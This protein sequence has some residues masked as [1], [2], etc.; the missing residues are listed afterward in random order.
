MH[1]RITSLVLLLCAA[2]LPSGAVAAFAANMPGLFTESTGAYVPPEGTN[3]KGDR[4][5]PV[6]L[7]A[8]EMGYD[9]TNGIVIARGKVEIV[10]GDMVMN[11]DQVT[12]FQK[13]DKMI[14]EGNI[15]MLQP[16][17]D[18]M[19][20]ER[21][22]LTDAMKKGVVEAFKARM[23]DNSLFV[24]SSATK[25]S[26]SVTELKG[27]S[28]T[29]CNICEGIEPFWQLNAKEVK[30]DEG[31]Q[32]VKYKDAS[33]DIYGVPVFYTPVLSHPTPNSDAKS[34][35]LAPQYGNNSNLGTLVKVPVYWRIDHDKDAIIT[36]WYTQ[37]DGLV[38]QGDYRQLTNNGEYHFQGAITNPDKID[39]AGNT[40]EGNELRGYIFAQGKEALSDTVNVGFDINR[41][42]DQTFLRRY[43]LGVQPTLFS[44]LFVEAAQ[45][46]NYGLVQGL[47]IQGLRT[48]D[49][50]KT[51][52]LILPSVQ[53][54]YETTPDEYGI[55]YHISQD[56][57]SLT[58]D[59]GVDQS[60]L[61][62]TAGASIPY[63][64]DGGHL[65]TT[66][67][68]LRQDAY[69]SVN[70]PISGVPQDN[71]TYR[72]LPQAAFEW[73]YPLIN[74]MGDGSMTIE[75]IA[76]GVLQANG[77]NPAT[78]SNEDSRLLE[79]SDTNIFSINRM[80]GLDLVDSGSRVA[81]GARTQYL[82]AD[83]TSLSGL[84][85]QNYSTDNST[86]F[87]NNPRGDEHFSDFVG[88]MA[89]NVNPFTFIYRFALD[90]ENLGL[91]RNEVSF[92]F[93][94]PWLA[95]QTSYTSLDKNS[96]IDESREGQLD[97]AFPLNESWSLHGGARRDFDLN[98]L[99]TENA[100]FIYKN[101]CF[102]IMFDVVRNFTRDRDVEPSTQYLVRVGF[103][104]LGE[105]GGR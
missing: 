53:S 103:K 70:V 22:Q 49:D 85:G 99:I 35:V 69:R 30:I 52:P 78:I 84:L 71:D 12:Y 9:Q 73:R 83:G 92:Y 25:V 10:Q 40:V 102:N 58:R 79:L 28:Y 90:K 61:S 3:L 100:G 80:P 32:R 46:R 60:R 76:L 39:S 81:Y 95:I 29:P 50:S 36:P 75:P 43:N 11:A 2:A 93:A 105:F 8:D 101:E 74:Q 87:P 45:D 41:T 59:T 56:A 82:F 17:G 96:F 47:A 64:S 20:A 27:A 19:F 97:I 48:T 88:R 37:N 91:N 6:V 26:P 33:M 34:G 104:N 57:Q 66:T 72:T 18:V 42:T 13:T 77:G 68:N 7:S 86:P 24:A 14:A 65:L 23:A 67:L 55:R 31:E 94:K 38:L 5:A 4:N 51:T 62:V 1:P 21:A 54:Y 63:V 15:S 98:E 44:R 89:Y 16:S